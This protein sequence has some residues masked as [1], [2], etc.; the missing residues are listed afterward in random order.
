MENRSGIVV[1]G[2]GTSSILGVAEFASV[3]ARLRSFFPAYPLSFGFLELAQPTIDQGMEVLAGKG[4]TSVLTV[5]LLLFAA[6]HAKSDIPAAVLQA[7]GKRRIEVIGQS[8][9]L[10][11]HPQITG[12]SLRRYR[13]KNATNERLTALVL[14]GRGSRDPEAQLAAAEFLAVCQAEGGL[15]LTRLA[16]LAMAKPDIREELEKLGQEA[17]ERVIVVPHLLFH[18]E[19]VEKC[20]RIVREFANRFPNTDWQLAG[21]LGPDQ[22]VVAATADRIAK[23]LLEHSQPGS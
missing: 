23:A 13:E 19:L 15:P 6:G 22:A 4:V 5:P 20:A 7:A 10:G 3:M 2:H 17:I 9:V 21:R 16:F 12:L 11:L 18:G 8:E 14:V 1:V